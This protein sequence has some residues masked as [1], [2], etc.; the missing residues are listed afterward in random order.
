MKGFGMD[1]RRPEE[2]GAM[3]FEPAP[4]LAR[5]IA[6]AAALADARAESPAS[7]ATPAGA[8]PRA[9][10]ELAAA[11]DLLLASIAKRPGWAYHRFLLGQLT[12]E[13]QTAPRD[14][15]RSADVET[16]ARP[17]RLAAAASPGLDAIWSAFA[18]MSLESWPKLS[19]QDQSA[20]TPVFRRALQDPHFVSAQ[21]LRLSGAVGREQA[22]ALLPESPELLRAAAEALTANGDLQVAAALL[23]RSEAAQRK[24][25]ADRLAK[26]EERFRMRDKN[27]LRA[28]CVEWANENAVAE[29]DEP[30]RRAE[31]ARVLELWPGYRGGPWDGD[32]RADLLRFFLDGRESSVDAATLSHTVDALSDVPDSVRARVKLRAGDLVS[33]QELAGRP[34]NQ[35]SPEWSLYY[36]DLARFLL[37]QGRAREARGAL[38]LISPSSRDEC[39]SLLARRDVALSLQ[40]Q[41]EVSL[42][43]SRLEAQRYG[44]RGQASEA[45]GGPLTLC[46]DPSLGASQA[47]NLRLIP[48]APAIVQYGW[49]GAHLATLFLPSER[50]VSIPLAGLSGRRQLTVR[51]IAGGPVRAALAAGSNR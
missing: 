15:Q 50:N 37:K 24:S 5:G 26:I 28:A 23:S 51:S 1:A 35:G 36:V 25:S 33:A 27:G 4:D 49:G 46:V 19:P 9:D 43:A 12:Y 18:T 7:S 44:S 16:W 29:L 8:T 39:D 14:S 22:M 17:M 40:D 45:D 13:L 21:F 31:A 47:V 38:D 48:Q 6:A 20:A 42:V 11:R 2:V 3:R 10:E 34:E 32:P 30:G 41:A